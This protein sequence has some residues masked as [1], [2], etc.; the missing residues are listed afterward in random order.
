MILRVYREKNPQ[1][2]PR[3]CARAEMTNLLVGNDAF[4]MESVSNLVTTLSSRPEHSVVDRSAVS[5]ELSEHR[6]PLQNQRP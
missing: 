5:F 2:S 4:S 1:V 3:R 6:Q